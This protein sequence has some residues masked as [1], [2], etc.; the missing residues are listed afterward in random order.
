MF[1]PHM[2]DTCLADQLHLLPGR[3]ERVETKN[4]EL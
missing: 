2:T 1:L 4:E 3:G